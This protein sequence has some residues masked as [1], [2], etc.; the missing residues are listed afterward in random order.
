MRVASLSVSPVD[1]GGNLPFFRVIKVDRRQ[2]PYNA[3]KAS[4]SESH[5]D[6]LMVATMPLLPTASVVEMMFFQLGL[7]QYGPDGLLDNLGKAIAAY[8]YLDL[9]PDPTAQ[10]ALNEADRDFADEFPN[11]SVW[12][13]SHGGLAYMRFDTTGE[14]QDN[15]SRVFLERDRGHF[16][17]DQSHWLCGVKKSCRPLTMPPRG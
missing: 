15:R 16:K 10:A 6:K 3:V 17:A 1:F 13:L 5:V 8:D 9:D 12:K 4:A 14:L 7:N 2:S 11:L